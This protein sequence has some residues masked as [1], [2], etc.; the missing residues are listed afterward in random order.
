M[1]I[2][3][4]NCDLKPSSRYKEETREQTRLLLYAF[5]P[6]LQVW[7]DA[8]VQIFY[9]LGPGWGGIVNMASYNRFHNNNK[10]YVRVIT[11]SALWNSEVSIV[12][13]KNLE[14]NLILGLLNPICGSILSCS[15]TQRI[16]YIKGVVEA[17]RL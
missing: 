12:H 3:N 17:F 10:W 4:T 6:L 5:R 9:S 16:L 14:L 11:L 15:T 2:Q 13:N 8:A 1:Q 7:A